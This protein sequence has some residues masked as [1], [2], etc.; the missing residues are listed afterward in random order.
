MADTLTVR[1][2]GSAQGVC[3]VDHGRPGYRDRGIAQGGPADPLAAATANR[4]LDQKVDGCCIELTL[5]GGHWQF[6]GRG[7]IALTGANMDWRL[8]GQPVEQYRVLNLEGEN[9]LRGGVARRQCRAYL[10]IRG[11][12]TV[13]RVLESAEAGLPGTVRFAEGTALRVVS[14]RWATPGKA[15]LVLPQDPSEPLLLAAEPGPEWR[16]LTARERAW[17]VARAYTVGA[18]SD[19]QGIR[20]S[21]A[22]VAERI[23]LPGMLSSAVLPGTVQLTP[24]G[25]ILLGPDA[26]TVGGYPR[27]LQVEDLAAAFQLPT[28]GR[29]RFVVNQTLRS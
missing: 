4:L 9:E 18:Q 21:A 20:L 23:R 27:L 12:W 13:P 24:A 17:L 26:Q 7:Q 8:N 15:S 25:P 11:E 6:S 10:G 28:G 14:A 29:L 22:G 5:L 1:R 19:R 3:L 2:I 16:L